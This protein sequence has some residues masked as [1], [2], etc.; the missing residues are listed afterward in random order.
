[1]KKIKFGERIRKVRKNAG[2]SQKEFCTALDI[3]QS[4]L[5]AYETDRMQ[6]T[7]ASLVNIAT[8]FNVSLDWLC[9]ISDDVE[10][11]SEQQDSGSSDT[12]SNELKAALDEAEKDLMEL[13][14]KHKNIEKLLCNKSRK[15]GSDDK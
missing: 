4:T 5:S 13:A 11:K 8:K 14:A 2:Y 9:G 6:P 3:P 7:V 12:L 10:Q 15:K 1:M